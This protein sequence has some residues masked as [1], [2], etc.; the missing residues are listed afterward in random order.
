MKHLEW[1]VAHADSLLVC[2]LTIIIFSKMSK[3][4]YLVPSESRAEVICS[5]PQTL[6][7][8]VVLCPRE[9]DFTAPPAPHEPAEAL[10][11]AGGVLWGPQMVSAWGVTEQVVM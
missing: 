4:P 1:G 3:H 6:K 11:E 7:Q 10:M 2:T 5:N 9:T 8:K